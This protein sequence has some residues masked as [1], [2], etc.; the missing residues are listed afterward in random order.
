M[1]D[2]MKKHVLI[3]G[4]V[5]ALCIS[6]NAINGF[7]ADYRGTSLPGDAGLAI[8]LNN[9]HNIPIQSG[10]TGGKYNVRIVGKTKDSSGN[11][12]VYF[13]PDAYAKNL[14]VIK[15]VHLDNDLW[16]INGPLGDRV[17]Q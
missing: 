6:I 5:I 12:Y 8:I 3:F 16:V 1:V 7:C 17:M 15:I 9:Y 14:S 13:Y 2:D 4:I 11:Y 10:T